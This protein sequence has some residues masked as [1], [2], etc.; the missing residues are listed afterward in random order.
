MR[1]KSPRIGEIMPPGYSA[2][3]CPCR[4]Y[5]QCS[6]VPAD[7]GLPGRS[8]LPLAEPT[9][10]TPSRSA[11]LAPP[12]RRGIAAVMRDAASEQFG[13]S[14]P[15]KD[16]W[17]ALLGRA[18]RRWFVIMLGCHHP[19]KPLTRINPLRPLPWRLRD[20]HGG[21]TRAN[22]SHRRRSQPCQGGIGLQTRSRPKA[23][24]NPAG[25]PPAEPGAVANAVTPQ[26]V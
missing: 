16:R 23:Y 21:V 8:A 2:T 4:T 11:A 20:D 1:G 6:R 7:S 17:I 14:V 12:A 3:H 13:N 24:R 26:G 25:Y 22:T 9:G 18:A 10:F 5:P 15:A 19:C